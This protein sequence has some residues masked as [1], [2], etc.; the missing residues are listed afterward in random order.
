Q[1]ADIHEG[2][3]STLTLLKSDISEKIKIVKEF[4]D[5]PLLFCS[6]GQ[7]NQ[8]FMSLLLNAIQSISETGT[9]IIKTY[10]KDKHIYVQITDTGKGIAQDKLENIFNFGFSTSKSRVKMGSGLLTTY[11]IIRKHKG[12]IKIESE[13]GVGSA[14]T[15]ILPTG[16]EKN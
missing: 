15:V 5:L 4:G 16:L 13:V 2:L 9:I 10:F 1:K 8:A 11:N 12:E 7:L 6:P 3:E 14:V